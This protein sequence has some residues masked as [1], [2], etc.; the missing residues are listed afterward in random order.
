MSVC[1]VSKQFPPSSKNKILKENPLIIFNLL[2]RIYPGNIGQVSGSKIFVY[3]LSKSLP[4]E[5]AVKPL[6]VLREL[7]KNE[8]IGP[9]SLKLQKENGVN[10]VALE[11]VSRAGF[12]LFFRCF[13]WKNLNPLALGPCAVLAPAA[14]SA[15][16]VACRSIS[17][18]SCFFPLAAF[19]S[20]NRPQEG[21]R[22]PS[23]K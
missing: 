16:A 14:Y 23:L 10:R 5:G 13:F 12:K 15:S 18:C 3:K 22:A 6:K 9:V 21:H 17:L 2:G 8:T 19:V 1:V 20:Y 11:A 4:P 7:Q